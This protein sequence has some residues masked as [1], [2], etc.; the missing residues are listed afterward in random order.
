M[1]FLTRSHQWHHHCGN[2][3]CGFASQWS[4]MTL[5]LARTCFA[6]LPLCKRLP[7]NINSPWRHTSSQAHQ[8]RVFRWFNSYIWPVFP[9][10]NWHF[11]FFPTQTHI[12]KTQ[13]RKDAVDSPSCEQKDMCLASKVSSAQ[14]DHSFTQQ[15]ALFN[16][17]ITQVWSLTFH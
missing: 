3:L 14:N 9:M 6:A 17:E 15:N 11:H 8:H 1:L 7:L 13:T 4:E 10:N 2:W 16:K 12:L 5:F